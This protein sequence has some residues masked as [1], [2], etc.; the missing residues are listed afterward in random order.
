V[1]GWR[2]WWRKFIRHDDFASMMCITLLAHK[3]MNGLLPL[4]SL[5]CPESSLTYMTQIKPRM[6]RVPRLLG[7]TLWGQIQFTMYKLCVCIGQPCK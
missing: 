1:E 3:K 5:H 2:L 4:R 7:M 6:L